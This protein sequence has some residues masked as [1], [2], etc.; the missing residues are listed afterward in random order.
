MR[1]S[2]LLRFAWPTQ[3][4]LSTEASHVGW[5]DAIACRHAGEI[6]GTAPLT[7]VIA[8]F[9]PSGK[10]G[11]I[12]LVCDGAYKLTLAPSRPSALCPRIA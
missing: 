8:V 9:A 11:P 7:H 12:R 6:G 3:S 10:L 5:W 2:T 4:R 1:T